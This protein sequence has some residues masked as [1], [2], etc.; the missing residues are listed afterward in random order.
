MAS[1]LCSIQDS[2]CEKQ[3]KSPLANCRETTLINALPNLPFYGW[4]FRVT[5]NFSI[6]CWAHQLTLVPQCEWAPEKRIRWTQKVIC[7]INFDS[8]HL[9]ETNGFWLE[10]LQNRVLHSHARTR[11]LTIN[12]HLCDGIWR[13]AICT[14]RNRTRV[15]WF[16]CSENNESNIYC[17]NETCLEIDAKSRSTIPKIKPIFRKWVLK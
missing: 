4:R 9:S 12:V 3:L 5:S 13:I 2:L 6:I 10:R 17:I 16:Y 11:T 14:W 8:L 15:L 1:N 7:T